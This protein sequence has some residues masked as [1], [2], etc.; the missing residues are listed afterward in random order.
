MTMGEPEDSSALTR[1]A[2]LC[3]D[4]LGPPTADEI[5]RGLDGFLAR[6]APGQARPRRLIRWSLAGAAVALGALAIFQIAP[7]LRGHPAAP[8]APMLTYRIDGGSVLEGGYLRESG[9]A[10]MIVTFSEGSSLALTVGTRGRIRVVDRDTAHVAIERGGGAFQVAHKNN[11]RWLVDVG[12]FLVT[13]TGTAFTASWDPVGEEFSL[14]LREGRVVVSGPVSAGEIPLR[15]GQRLVA[16]LARVETVIT[17]DASE[18]ARSEPRDAA[19]RPTAPPLL[20]QP[21]VSNL[22]KP[23]PTA[24]AKPANDHQW[25]RKLARGKWERILEEAKRGGVDAT[26]GEASSEDL[27]A[28]ANAA[29]YRQNFDLARSALLAERRRFPGSSRALE[30]AYVLGR[31]EES[32]DSEIVRAIGWYDEYLTR[33]PTGPLAGEALGRKMTLTDKLEG[34]GRA[35]SLA[36]EYLRRF[37]KGNYAGSARELLSP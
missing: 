27:L 18:Q 12:P 7:A 32:R 22:A 36:E 5:G 37:P 24:V 17:E 34:P 21:S 20:P 10:G 33:A 8:E 2:D 13:V 14:K 1:A 15:A 29:R 19:P 28:L 25:S 9:H 26:L 11:R 4:T 23:V 31:V 3:R 35:R 6:V 16:N 30:A